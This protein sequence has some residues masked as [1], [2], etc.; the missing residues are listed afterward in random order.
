M[1]TLQQQTSPTADKN[2]LPLSQTDPDAAKQK[3][4]EHK[5]Q[6]LATFQAMQ[7]EGKLPHNAQLHELLDK[8]IENRVISSREHLVSEDGKLLLNDF[9][10]LLRTLQKALSHKNKDELFQSLV[11]HL[12][13]MESPISKGKKKP[14]HKYDLSSNFVYIDHVNQA[15][16]SHDQDTMKDEGKKGKPQ[17]KPLLCILIIPVLASSALFNILKLMLIN[18]EFRSV[19]G[20]LLDISQDIFNDVAGKAGQSLQDAGSN[21]QDDNTTDRSGKHFVDR[22]LDKALDYAERPKD[23]EHKRNSLHDQE[24]RLLDASK[25]DPRHKGLLNTGDSVHPAAIP[26]GFPRANDESNNFQDASLQ[27]P[28]YHG[29][30]QEELQKPKEQVLNH[31]MYQDTRNKL[32]EHKEHARQTANEKMPKDK[33][34]ELIRRLQ[35]ALAQVQD[36]PDYQ[37]SINTIIH[38]VKVWGSRLS[39]VTGDLKQQA[40]QNDHPQQAD[41]RDQAEREVKAIIEIWAQGHSIDPL[42]QAIQNVTEDMRNDEHLRD[43]Y[44][45]VFDYLHRLVKEPGYISTDR[46]I[47]DGKRL[48]DAGRDIVKGRYGDHL[49]NL[50]SQGRRYVRLIADD[51]VSRDLAHSFNRIHRDL[52]MDR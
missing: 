30:R 35:R 36:H 23:R 39:N 17:Y 7:R 6:L 5:L 16:K 1:S 50:S 27:H 8:L 24:P 40:K 29:G 20:E 2:K 38:L 15:V 14:H 10:N 45:T 3:A 34:D 18:N 33:Q 46:S 25:D 47:D 44:H 52:W 37:E 12:H 21:L 51:E 43:Y 31:P 48:M 22:A 9:R 4:A 28:M 13:C 11:Y 41:Y 19:L 32:Q 42:L 49:D 26:G